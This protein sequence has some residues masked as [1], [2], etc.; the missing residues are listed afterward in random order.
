MVRFVVKWVFIDR[1]IVHDIAI[2][3]RFRPKPDI[4]KFVYG[5]ELVRCQPTIPPCS[6]LR[7]VKHAGKMD[8]GAALDRADAR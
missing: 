3:D 5:K 2:G 1:G 8:R 4:T 6:L 7:K